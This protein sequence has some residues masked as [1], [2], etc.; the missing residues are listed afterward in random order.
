[1]IFKNLF[2][3]LTITLILLICFYFFLISDYVIPG[4]ERE[5]K[6]FI[7][8]KPTIVCTT[9]IIA[10]AIKNIADDT[11]NLKI[12]MGPGVDPHIYKPVEQD[13][14]KISDA[15]LI[16]YNGLHLEARMA[17]IFE[18]MSEHKKT[19]AVSCNMPQ[20]QFI[21]S[22]EFEQYPDPHVWFDPKLWIYAVHTITKHLQELAPQHFDLYEKNNNRY[23]EKILATYQTTKNLMLKIPQ[24]RRILITGHDA[25]SYFARAYD[26]KVISLQGIST[27]SE[28]GTCDVQNLIN[29]IVQHKIKTIFPESCIPTRSMQ[30]LMQGAESADWNVHLG[31]ELFSDALGSPGS[32]QESYCGML[33]WNVNSMVMGLIK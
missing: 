7:S 22:C 14:I 8:N 31:H 25:F 18:Q 28:A 16:F 6:S 24:E 21:Y 15:D 5:S 26:C 29:F 4:F 1:M 9:T 27:A 19:V 30:A 32:A 2:L 12:L 33:Q 20:G 10:D 23:V 3:G 17:D 11:I 13:I